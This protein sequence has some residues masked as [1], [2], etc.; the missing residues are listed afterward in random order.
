MVYAIWPHIGKN[1]K[2]AAHQA[3]R[4]ELRS[5]SLDH[6][7]FARVDH[8]DSWSGREYMATVDKKRSNRRKMTEKKNL[9]SRSRDDKYTAPQDPGEN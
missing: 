1:V 4:A 5:C 8:Y 2:R 6:A 3:N 7:E 9:R